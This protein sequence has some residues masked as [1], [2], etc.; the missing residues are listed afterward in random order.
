[1]RKVIAFLVLLSFASPVLAQSPQLGAGQVFGNNTGAGPRPGKATDLWNAA[2]IFTAG[3]QTINPASGTTSRGLVVNQTFP[4]G[5]AT[6]PLFGNVLTFINPGFTATGAGT[7]D[8][9]GQ[10][11]NQVTGLRINYASTGPTTSSNNIA[12][13]VAH[14]VTAATDAV[15]GA[16][17]VTSD[18][19]AVGGSYLWGAIG[20]ANVRPGGTAGLLIGAE[21][22]VAIATGASATYRIGSGADS[23]GA[24]TGTTLDTAF[25]ATASSNVMPGGGAVTGWNHLLT[26]AKTPYFS[27]VSPINPTGDFFFSDSAIT[28]AHFANLANVTVTG[29]I[30]SFPNLIIAGNGAAAFGSL[31][32]PGPGNV[33]SSCASCGTVLLAGAPNVTTGANGLT[34]KD[35]STNNLLY[36]GTVE[37]AFTGSR[38]GQVQGNWAELVS[39]GSTNAGLGIGTLT[40]VPLILGTN[41]AA[42]MTISG[43][44]VTTFSGRVGIGSAV[45]PDV[46]LMVNSNTGTPIAPSVTFDAHLIG[47]AGANGGLLSEVHAGEVAITGRAGGTSSTPAVPTARGAA[48]PFMAISAETYDG[49]AWVGA[50][51]IEF[52]TINAQ[53]TIDHSARAR[54][55]LAPSG[56]TVLTD[57]M[58]WG[59]G[60]AIGSGAADPGAGNLNLGGGSLLN[61]GVAPTGTGAYVRASAPVITL[62]NATGLPISTGL[63]GVG[64]GVLAA[65]GVNVG[66]A[67][68]IVVNGGAL[69]T[70]SSGVG[71]NITNVNAST[72]GGATF[73]APGAIGSGTPGTGA[74][75]ALTASTYNGNTFT[76]GT[77]TLT[78][79]AGKTVTLNASTTF[80]GAD[81]KTL[82]INNTLGL[83]GTDGTVM[84]FPTST[85]TIART[86]AGQTF[87][88]TNVFGVVSATGGFISNGNVGVTKTCTEAVGQVLTFTLGILTGTTGAGCV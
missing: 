86:D 43:A 8:A 48:S 12:S 52:L 21:A 19:S 84:T 72:L 80:S 50:G 36:T 58:L 40:N 68:S 44:G 83:N 2:N 57:V 27:G 17:G 46:T 63:T 13:N 70:P 54:L 14:Y 87:T 75:T 5:S 45:A 42:R 22:E 71:T 24:V 78:I 77:G 56:S 65:L 55:V 53:T 69:G 66:T 23:Q 25:A 51:Y 60:V 16:M 76:T 85:A 35:S 79:A 74:F 59:P 1:M 31:A 26:V 37:A 34:V 82:Q 10:I 28:V 61:N 6:G 11:N 3:P 18:S 32:V 64:T 47:A 41:N 20:Y 62:T 9:F 88:G 73:A 4:S 81:G 49:A 38:F 30:L 29:N 33:L 39:L 67:S 15:G 7:T